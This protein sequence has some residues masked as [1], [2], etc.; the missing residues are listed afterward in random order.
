MPSSSRQQH[1][2]GSSPQSDGVVSIVST[3]NS[4][5]TSLLEACIPPTNPTEIARLW[6][7]VF[8]YQDQDLPTGSSSS[9]SKVLGPPTMNPLQKSVEA[10]W[11]NEPPTRP[12]SR[13]KHMSSAHGRNADTA[14]TKANKKHVKMPCKIEDNKIPL[15]SAHD[16]FCLKL[17]NLPAVGVGTSQGSSVFGI[18]ATIFQAVPGEYRLLDSCHS[19]RTA[20]A[21]LT[22][23][24][25]FGL[26]SLRLA[27]PTDGQAKIIKMNTSATNIEHAEWREPPNWRYQS[28]KAPSPF[29]CTFWLSTSAFPKDLRKCLD[30]YTCVL[31]GAMILPYLTVDF[32]EEHEQIDETRQRAACIGVQTLFNRRH[33]YMRTHKGIPAAAG[34]QDYPFCCHFMIIFD[35]DWCEGWEITAD[36]DGIWTDESCTMKRIFLS[37]L[38]TA[39]GV[40]DLYTW[41]CEIHCWGATKYGPACMEEITKFSQ[42]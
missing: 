16:H 13:M 9:D 33:L 14:S 19:S 26:D 12:G 31:G 40:E 22:M 3:Q 21:Q 42:A 24:L 15:P 2:S 17:G 29:A 20:F 28:S 34:K 41:I 35:K 11:L 36:K 25:F 8:E 30:Y 6:L 10:G 7:L 5:P 32:R 23:D 37:T 38:Y 39:E 1:I 4:Q 18:D 27:V